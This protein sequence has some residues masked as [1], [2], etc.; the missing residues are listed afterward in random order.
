MAT[1][2]IFACTLVGLLGAAGIAQADTAISVIGG[3][4]LQGS[5]GMRV[6]FDATPAAAYVQDNSPNAEANYWASFRIRVNSTN[7]TDLQS[8][9]ILRAFQTDGG[10][11]T[12]F[13]VN[14]LKRPVGEVN[15]YAIHVFPFL[16]GGGVFAPRLAVAIQHDATDGQIFAIEFRA[17]TGSADGVMRVYRDGSL[18]KTQTGINNDDLRVGM[19]RFGAPAAPAAT[20]GSLD[21]DDFVSTRTCPGLPCP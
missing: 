1:R 18:R 8:Q 13:R 10:G 3:A 7:M 12:A 16:D 6:A 15:Q 5:F 19:I 20:T 14:L 17:G 4:A 21:L 11:G 2:K 9:Q